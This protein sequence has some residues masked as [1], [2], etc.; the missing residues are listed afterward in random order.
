VVVY[1]ATEAVE[2]KLKL[3]FV[4]NALVPYTISNGK[5]YPRLNR[6]EYYPMYRQVQHDTGIAAAWIMAGARK[7]NLGKYFSHGIKKVPK[8]YLNN[9]TPP[10]N[11]NRGP[12]PGSPRRNCLSTSLRTKNDGKNFVKNSA[13]GTVITT[14]AT[15]TI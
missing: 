7:E 12:S 10:R 1:F 3:Q 2:A 14:E 5:N 15:D 6:D 11:G 4:E 13:I 9:D 8:E